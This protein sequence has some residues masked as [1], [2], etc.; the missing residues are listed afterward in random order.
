MCAESIP[1]KRSLRNLKNALNAFLIETHQ[2]PSP[3]PDARAQR[4]SVTR[5]PFLSSSCRRC[6][7]VSASSSFV[8]E[9]ARVPSIGGGASPEGRAGVAAPPAT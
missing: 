4:R 7:S 1:K 9:R 5:P 6:L 3:L 8:R 2:L